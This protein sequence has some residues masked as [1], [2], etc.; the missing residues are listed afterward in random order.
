MTLL[1]IISTVLFTGC[2]ET[3]KDSG[4][5]Q[6]I[7]PFVPT[8]GDWDLLSSP[9]ENDCD[10]T[11]DESS[12]AVLTAID[13]GFTFLVDKEAAE[14]DPV[15]TFTCTLRDMSFT[16]A[17]YSAQESE[18]GNTFTQVI[19]F[20]GSFADEN[21]MT[22]EASLSMSFGTQSCSGIVNLSATTIP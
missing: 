6:Q 8:E 16:C 11:D 21:T 9:G 15:P 3:E 14:G 19:D 12:V 22:G 13:G 4:E 7:E 5:E 2:S 1:A 10:F 18:G 17:Q 20:S